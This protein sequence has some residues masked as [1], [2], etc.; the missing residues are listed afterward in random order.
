MKRYFINPETSTLRAGW[1]IGVFIVIFLAIN[2]V[3]SVSVREINGS[4]KKMGTLWFTVL[5]VSATIAAYISRKYID[6][7]D[8]ISLGLKPDRAAVLD[9]V[10][11]VINSALVMTVMYFTLLFAGL[12][13][14]TGYSWWTDRVG[15]D[16]QM[17]MAVMPV[18]LGVF[19][20]LVV[21]AWWEELVNRGIILQN[22]IKGVGLV[23]AVV[24]SATLFG[25]AHATNQDA[26][27][28]STIQIILIALQLIYAYFKTGQLWL[29]IGLHLGWNFFQAS[30]FGFASSGH[31]S[32]AMIMHQAVGP[33]WLSGGAFGAEGSILIIP[34]LIASFY[35]I[36]WWAS[37]TRAPGQKFFG[38][39]VK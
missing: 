14:F 12:I 19:W 30:I 28:L 22:L 17:S 20:Q 25:L 31:R 37:H 39:L 13:E 32:P 34:Y 18:V 15:D 10:S 38:F 7:A 8:L 35:L 23:W 1:R 36:H 29:P 5:G 21:V 24:L 4:L 27:V 6:K 11:G 2:L 16:I 3:L 9:I 33:D 26:T